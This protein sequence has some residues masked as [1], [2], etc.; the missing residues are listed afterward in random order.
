MI[1]M[2]SIKRGQLIFAS[3]SQSDVAPDDAA[4]NVSEMFASFENGIPRMEMIENTDALGALQCPMLVDCLQVITAV[5]HRILE[6]ILKLT[7][8]SRHS[9]PSGKRLVR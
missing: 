7:K 4:V 1:N 9:L 6:Y 5:V 8:S 2:L 3:G